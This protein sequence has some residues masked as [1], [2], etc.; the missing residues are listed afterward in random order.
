MSHDPWGGGSDADPKLRLKE[1]GANDAPRQK[2]V[3]RV[4]PVANDGRSAEAIKAAAKKVPD[5]SV[6][7]ALKAMAAILMLIYLISRVFKS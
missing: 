3:V 7:D 4:P 5:L 6:W 1:L 2:I